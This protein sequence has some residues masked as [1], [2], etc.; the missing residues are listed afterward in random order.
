MEGAIG[1]MLTELEMETMEVRLELYGSETNLIPELT[2]RDS[3][4]DQKK[5]KKK[6]QLGP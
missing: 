1:F 4:V 2:V 5:K 6:G 3:W